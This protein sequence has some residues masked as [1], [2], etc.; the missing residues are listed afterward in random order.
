MRLTI[1]DH[2]FADRDACG[3]RFE[4]WRNWQTYAFAVRGEWKRRELGDEPVPCDWRRSALSHDLP[5][6]YEPYWAAI[7]DGELTALYVAL[8]RARMG[9]Q[10]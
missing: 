7:P 8:E 9:E 2:Y 6:A 1:T 5:V 3:D 4:R 10:P